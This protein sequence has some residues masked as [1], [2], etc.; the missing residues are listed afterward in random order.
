MKIQAPYLI[1]LTLNDKDVIHAINRIAVGIKDGAYMPDRTASGMLQ[2]A[3]TACVGAGFLDPAD[4]P[5]FLTPRETAKLRRTTINQL[6]QE[7][8]L[9]RGPKFI[10]DG[11]RILYSRNDILDYLAR[12][13]VQR[14]DDP[15]GAA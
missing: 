3:D 10:K 4:L 6:A 12:N 8:Y 15:R 2:E 13:T 11:R 9:G 1:P 14:T 5:P 7:R